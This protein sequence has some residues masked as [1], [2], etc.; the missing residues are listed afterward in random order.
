[1][2]SKLI[3]FVGHDPATWTLIR[4]CACTQEVAAEQ[5]GDLE[6]F[7]SSCQ[8]GQI[9]C[10]LVDIDHEPTAPDT[11]LQELHRR[12]WLGP[13]ILI[14]STTDAA[15]IVRALRRGA[16]DYLQKP[17][18]QETL[19]AAIGY[20]LRADDER[21]V[22]LE[23]YA[24]L[25]ARL[26]QMTPTEREV[27][28]RMVDGQPNKQIAAELDMGLRTV[29]LRRA[30]ILE[31]MDAESLADLVRMV[32]TLEIVRQWVLRDGP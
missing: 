21:R 11:V 24:Q 26:E 20:A 6:Q 13:V 9:A 23:Q 30:R 29:E 22:L 12:R 32:T 7:L 2:A 14:G 28:R 17:C 16:A 25:T 8:P 1:M 5:F 18:S 27:M 15:L 10:T 3:G 31:K 19:S 4:D